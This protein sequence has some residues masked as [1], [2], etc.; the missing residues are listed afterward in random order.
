MKILIPNKI[1][2]FQI[3][4]GLILKQVLVLILSFDYKF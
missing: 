1:G 4:F 3:T 2:H